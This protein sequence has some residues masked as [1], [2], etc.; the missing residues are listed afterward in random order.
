MPRGGELD[1]LAYLLD[2]GVRVALIYGTLA[3]STRDYPE[4]TRS[5][6]T[7]I[8]SATIWVVKLCLSQ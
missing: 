1:D 8:T 4:L 2:R 6:V 3:V 7:A 5:Q